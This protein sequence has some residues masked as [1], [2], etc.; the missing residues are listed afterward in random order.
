MLNSCFKRGIFP[1]LQ[2]NGD[3]NHI[4][5][6]RKCRSNLPYCLMKSEFLFIKLQA[7]QVTY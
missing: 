2:I 7:S 4:D 1:G 3:E 5:D 6:A